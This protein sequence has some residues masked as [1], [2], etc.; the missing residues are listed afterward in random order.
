MR[1]P[2]SA[3]LLTLSAGALALGLSATSAAAATATTWT[4]SPGG[5]IKGAASTTTVTDTTSGLA[6]TC[7]TSTLT[8]TLKK[9]KGL[10]GA[11]LGTVTNV[12]FNNCSVDGFTLSIS[13]GAVKW[14]LNAVTY[15]NG[16]THG[17]ITKIHV[18]VSSSECS[19]VIDGTSGTADNGKVAITYTN[20]THKL[21]ILT[22]GSTLHVWDVSGCLGAISNGDAGTI[23][24]SYAITPAQTI[25]GSA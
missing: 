10:A 11:G 6:L 1:K 20:S 3:A 4:V 21:A 5:A 14:P 7:K 12:A 25:T 19:A 22:T 2:I 8:G 16:V 23:K 18:S 17:T 9:G 15:S 24:S 13:S